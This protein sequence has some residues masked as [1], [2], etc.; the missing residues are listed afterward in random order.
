MHIKKT[1]PAAGGGLIFF[2]GCL[3]HLSLLLSLMKRGE[4]VG[5][6][7]GPLCYMTIG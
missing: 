5:S 7:E 1:T 3:L 4:C 6:L 2:L